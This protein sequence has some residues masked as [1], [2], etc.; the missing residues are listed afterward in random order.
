LRDRKPCYAGNVDR[1]VEERI[2][3]RHLVGA[4]AMAAGI[5]LAAT[6]QALAAPPT[7]V[8][9][10]GYERR[11]VE[12]RKALGSYYY[13]EG[14]VVVAPRGH[15]RHGRSHGRHRSHR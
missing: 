5:G 3:I 14:P 2:M 9:S 1:L 10:P 12:S 7:V 15:R 8:P 11:L 13:D 4:A 6:V